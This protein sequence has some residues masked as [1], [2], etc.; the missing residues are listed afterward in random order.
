MAA[1]PGVA[2][3]SLTD[4]TREAELHLGQELDIPL[5]SSPMQLVRSIARMARASGDPRPE[6]HSGATVLDMGFTAKQP[7]PAIT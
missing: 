2:H 6:R 4:P 1:A 5:R 3:K 7:F